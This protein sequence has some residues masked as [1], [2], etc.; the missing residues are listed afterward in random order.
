M[1]WIKDES[2]VALVYVLVIMTVVFL[3]VGG[4]VTVTMAENQQTLYQAEEISAYYVARAGA[5]SM[6]TELKRMNKVKFA[7]FDAQQVA[8]AANVID[9]DGDGIGDEGSAEVSVEKI[10]DRYLIT[11]TGTFSGAQAE[12]KLWMSY[13]EYTEFDFAAYAKE[14]IGDSGN[15]SNAVNVGEI[16]G[17]IS[18]GGNIYYKDAD[19]SNGNINPDDVV[20]FKSKSIPFSTPD[21][22]TFYSDISQSFNNPNGAMVLTEST[23]LT[24]LDFDGS[25]DSMTIDTSLAE[26]EKEDVEYGKF[27]MLTGGTDDWMILYIEGKGIITKGIEVTGSKNLMIIVDDALFLS[28]GLTITP[29]G[30]HYPKVELYVT[31][32]S[33][34]SANSDVSNNNSNSNGDYDLVL[35][36]SDDYGIPTMPENL[37]IKLYGKLSEDEKTIEAMNKMAVNNNSDISGYIMGP[38]ATVELRNGQTDIYGSVYANIIES[39]QDVS[40]IHPTGTANTETIYKELD[41]DHWE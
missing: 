35:Y 22:T 11:S 32:E 41:I 4:I 18:S 10:G 1:K 7:Q 16:S 26:F 6:V 5:E 24:N 34:D 37:L 23:I 19:V 33:N 8:T 17:I 2:G 39:D 21:T 27:S 20:P 28:G 3:L 31:D 30:S 9:T 29:S 13:S 14:Q 36:G 15:D 38:E 25:H 40:I 12:V